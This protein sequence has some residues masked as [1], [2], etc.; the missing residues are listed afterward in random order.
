MLVQL[1][2]IH[3]EE[4]THLLT[5]DP[6]L[7]ARFRKLAFKLLPN[8]ELSGNTALTNAQ[9]GDI[10][11]LL[12]SIQGKSSDELKK[13]IERVREML[14]SGRLFKQVGVRVER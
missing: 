6:P 7:S 2:N 11:K 12:E 4:L 10:V 14:E 9:Y 8:L 13:D 3:A 5:T 1:Y